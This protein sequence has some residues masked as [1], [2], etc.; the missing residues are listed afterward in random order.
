MAFPQIWHDLTDSYSFVDTGIIPEP[1][2]SKLMAAGMQFASIDD[3]V[4]AVLRVSCDPTIHGQSGLSYMHIFADAIGRSLAVIPRAFASEGY[5]D[6]E[7]DDLAPE[8][9]LYAFEQM[10][11]NMKV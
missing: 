9:N 10:A 4:K 1:F 2:K 3:A 11:L 5:V 6:L 7:S 8:D